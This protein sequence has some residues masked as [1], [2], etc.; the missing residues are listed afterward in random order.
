MFCDKQVTVT[1]VFSHL[2]LKDGVKHAWFQNAAD[3]IYKIKGNIKLDSLL[4]LI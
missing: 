3:L 2:L 1:F 4:D